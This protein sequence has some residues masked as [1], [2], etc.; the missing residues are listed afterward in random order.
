MILP[1]V[2]CITTQNYTKNGA[3][4]PHDPLLRER[5]SLRIEPCVQAVLT[6]PEGHFS[7][8]QRQDGNLQ[9]SKL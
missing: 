3:G 9:I 8:Q 6:G 7:F 2:S 4:W 5:G 1:K